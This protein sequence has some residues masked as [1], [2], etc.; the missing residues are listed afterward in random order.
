[1][2]FLHQAL[3]QRHL[4]HWVYYYYYEASAEAGNQYAGY[5]V[6][7]GQGTLDFDF[8]NNTVGGSFTYDTFV[9]YTSFKEGTGTYNLITSIPDQLL[10]CRM[11]RFQA[12]V[13]QHKSL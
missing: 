2:M 12:I 11:E 6:A 3:L 8:S 1:M 9:P 5:I 4:I 10:I 13:F 7:D